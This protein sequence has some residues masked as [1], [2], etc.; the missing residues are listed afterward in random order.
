M[1]NTT[2]MFIISG[3]MASL[4]SMFHLKPSHTLI[5]SCHLHEGFRTDVC[6]VDVTENLPLSPVGPDNLS[7]RKYCLLF[8]SY[9]LSLNRG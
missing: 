3:Q 7:I 2:I 4:I 5:L 1:T 8:S 9:I 6:S